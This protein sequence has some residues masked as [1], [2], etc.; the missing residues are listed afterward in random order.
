MERIASPQV[1][2]VRWKGIGHGVWTD[3]AR[4]ERELRAFLAE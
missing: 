2:I 4:Y 1:R 3:Q